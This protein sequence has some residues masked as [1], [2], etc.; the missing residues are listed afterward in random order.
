MRLPIRS[1]LISPRKRNTTGDFEQLSC[2]QDAISRTKVLVIGLLIGDSLIT[3]VAY[4]ILARGE[5]EDGSP[6]R[7]V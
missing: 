5:K 6:K 4:T 1:A 7:V 2:W 3:A